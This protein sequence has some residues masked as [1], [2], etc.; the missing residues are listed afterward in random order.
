MR[1][2]S[3]VQSL[4]YQWDAR[5]NLLSRHDNRQGLQETFSYDGLRIKGSNKGVGVISD[6]LRANLE[7]SHEC[8]ASRD[9][10]W[11]KSRAT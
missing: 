9:T 1:G 4:S 7:R 8:R 3:T 10:I 5:G 11:R 6:M 2:S